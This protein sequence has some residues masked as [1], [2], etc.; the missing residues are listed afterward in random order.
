VLKRALVTAASFVALAL[1]AAPGAGATEIGH[2]QSL[3]G[4]GGEN[5][6]TNL[7]WVQTA[8][9]SANYTVPFD[10][11][12]TSWSVGDNISTAIK[13]KV[14]RPVTSNAYNVIAS[15][16]PRNPPNGGISTYQVRFPV[17]QGDS[18][19]MQVGTGHYCF[20]GY[21]AVPGDVAEPV[22]GDPAVGQAI[23]VGGTSYASTRL[24]ISATVEPDRDGD[25]YGDET[26]DACPTLAST[27]G[28]CPLPTT[29]G[30]TFTPS[31]TSGGGCNGLT[32]IPLDLSGP[33]A[34]VV[35]AAPADGVITSWAFEGGSRVDGTV[36]LKTFRP[37]GGN[38]Y[39]TVG[40]EGPHAPIAGALASFPA[41]LPVEQDDQ[42]GLTVTGTVDCG[43]GNGTGQEL[44]FWGDPPIGT[45]T[46]F[47]PSTYST[48][49]SAVL[50]AD[51]DGDGYGDTTQDLCPTDPSTQ[52]ACASPP[53]PGDDK[54][55]EKARDKLAKAKAKLKKL[56]KKDAPAKKV[57]KAKAKVKKAKE[58]VKK[59]C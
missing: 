10:G 14:L 58:R 41:R 42:I 5:C 30:E 37:V 31:M 13:L 43:N 35:Y 40:E 44:S 2:A 48:D 8:A 17:R 24:P 4:S 29:L 54:A 27:Q 12:I 34:G 19:A 6:G 32:K 25:G 36:T 52:G 22:S 3:S 15:D 56:K 28:S 20:P 59:A 7:T 26:Q 53:P 23:G 16:G 50:E 38:S 39:R 49:L 21:G 51:A 1:A 46:N 9:S 11:V 18:I 47:F 57:K 55:C 33:D 45:T